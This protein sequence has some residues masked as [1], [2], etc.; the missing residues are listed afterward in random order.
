M[1]IS[2]PEATQPKVTEVIQYLEH[3][4]K[5]TSSN[6]AVYRKEIESPSYVTKDEASQSHNKQLLTDAL[7]E[8]DCLNVVINMLKW[9]M[10]F[11]AQEPY[12][13]EKKDHIPKEMDPEVDAM[14]IAIRNRVAEKRQQQQQQ[15]PA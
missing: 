5:V 2:I 13:P 4:Q 12:V 7:H 10:E 6:V 15:Q 14:L 1:I 3:W 11:Q 8:V 9:E